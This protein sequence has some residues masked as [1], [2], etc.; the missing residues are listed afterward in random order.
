MR[1]MEKTGGN[2]GENVGGMMRKSLNK[3]FFVFSGPAQGQGKNGLN[4]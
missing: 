2:L 1:A 3:H 4:E